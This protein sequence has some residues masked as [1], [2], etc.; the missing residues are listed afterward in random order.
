MSPDMMR[1]AAR[2]WPTLSVITSQWA[3]TTSTVMRL[4]SR[5]SGIEMP[6]TPRW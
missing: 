6:S 2:Y 4:F 1:K 3:I 5:M